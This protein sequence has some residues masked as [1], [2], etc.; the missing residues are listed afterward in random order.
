MNLALGENERTER[1]LGESNMTRAIARV[2]L[3]VQ[4]GS[5][6]EGATI[7]L[8]DRG[9]RVLAEY[10]EARRPVSNQASARL[11]SSRAAWDLRRSEVPGASR[12]SAAPRRC[13]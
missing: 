4:R 6:V 3:P 1:V 8:N 5:L 11:E 12:R 9:V 2:I 13:L 10:A 7:K